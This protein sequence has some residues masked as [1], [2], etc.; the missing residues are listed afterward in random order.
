MGVSFNACRMQAEA[1]WVIVQGLGGAVLCG[2]GS[3][4]HEVATEC[5]SA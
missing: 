4:A 1:A 3:G 2:S 5:A